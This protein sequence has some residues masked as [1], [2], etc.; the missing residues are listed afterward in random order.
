MVRATAANFGRLTLRVMPSEPAML[1]HGEAWERPQG[2]DRFSINLTAG[3]HRIEIRKQGYASYV[4]SIDVPRGQT[5]T[6][7][8]ALAHGSMQVA[9]TVPLR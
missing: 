5:I 9:R 7:N 1:L 2:D 3:L 8:V 6:L 4:R